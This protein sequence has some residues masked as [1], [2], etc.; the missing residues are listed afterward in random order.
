[1]DDSAHLVN[2]RLEFQSISRADVPPPGSEFTL[3]IQVRVRTERDDQVV[4]VSRGFVTR[5]LGDVRRNRDRRFSQLMGQSE[6]LPFWKWLYE[7]ALIPGQ[8]ESVFHIYVV[9][10]FR[11]T[12]VSPAKAGHY[13]VLKSALT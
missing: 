6:V 2:L 5:A 4:Y 8:N 9:S 11:R 3:D 12:S 7:L 10:A 1:M 13:I